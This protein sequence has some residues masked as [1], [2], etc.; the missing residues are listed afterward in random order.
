[1]TR[2]TQQLTMAFEKQ[3][4]HIS[5]LLA[6]LQEKETALLSQ[7]EEL[8]H[9]K[10]ELDALKAKKEEEKEERKTTMEMTDEEVEDGEQ[11]GEIQEESS[12]EISGL[13]PNQEKECAVSL[14]D[15][16]SNV[17]RDVGQLKTVASEAETPT[18]FS[19][20]EASEALLS[21]KQHSDAVD[22]ERTRSNY[23]SACVTG[24]TE[25]SQERGTADVFAELL[26]LQQ[27]N[28]LLK[29][30]METLTISNNTKPDLQALSENQILIKQIKNTE[31]A[32]PSS[33]TSDI[34]A[35]GEES[36]LDNEEKVEEKR[37]T[38]AEEAVE[39]MSKLQI[40]HLEQQV[41]TVCYVLISQ[42][43]TF[44]KDEKKC[45]VNH[46]K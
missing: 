43:D 28:Q 35:E 46:I 17:Q 33:L 9:Y 8:Q 27:E 19:S 12:V 23:N 3:S 15:D 20:E 24:D 32:V 39:D 29:E 36:L 10:Q 4:Q 1:M 7:G 25:W 30:K 37:T 44:N 13:Q 41:V 21:G 2:Q 5:G 34:T 26:A 6:E 42:Q 22:S 16:D 18:S 11:K 38:W 45:Q 14:A 31:N 40:N